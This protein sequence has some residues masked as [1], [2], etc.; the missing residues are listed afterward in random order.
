M[1]FLKVQ[2]HKGITEVPLKGNIGELFS[3]ISICP[4][5]VVD[6][7]IVVIECAHDA[8][9]EICSMKPKI[10]SPQMSRTLSQNLTN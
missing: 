8:Q 2:E 7:E 9:G 5:T 4:C 1:S 6:L 10:R 3:E